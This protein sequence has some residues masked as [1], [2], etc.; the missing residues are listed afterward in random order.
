MEQSKNNDIHSLRVSKTLWN[1]IIC[2]SKKCGITPSAYLRKLIKADKERLPFPEM[3]QEQYLLHK[4]RIH[5]IN[6]LT[7]EINSIGININQI[8]KHVNS[9]LYSDSEKKQLIELQQNLINI[10]NNYIERLP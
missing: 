8:A 1:H 7:Y 10:V 9:K 3:T 4:E 2:S 6:Q 5:S